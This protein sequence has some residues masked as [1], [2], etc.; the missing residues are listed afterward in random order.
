MTIQD[1]K[2]YVDSIILTM[3]PLELLFDKRSNYIKNQVYNKFNIKS[4]D[5]FRLF[6]ASNLPNQN[7]EDFENEISSINRSIS[8]FENDKNVCIDN[9]T[10]SFNDTFYP[11]SIY[12][13]TRKEEVRAEFKKK[14]H[15]L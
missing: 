14:F 2:T 6:I 13:D 9:F 8:S 15:L 11:Y 12:S 3:S 10:L 4:D 7:D 1:I 5:D